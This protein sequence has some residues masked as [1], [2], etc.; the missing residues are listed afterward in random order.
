MLFRGKT[1]RWRGEALFCKPQINFSAFPQQPEA[2]PGQDHGA[3]QHQQVGLGGLALRPGKIIL[4]EIR[5]EFL[6][7]DVVT[8]F[9][10]RILGCHFL[11]YF[12][13]ARNHTDKVTRLI[14]M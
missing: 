13:L 10:S 6:Y 3:R 5:F 4:P 7:M 8:L 11:I 14:A 9:V 1:H 12:M 2:C